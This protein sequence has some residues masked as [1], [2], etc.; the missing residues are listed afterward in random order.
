MV[1]LSSRGESDRSRL[2]NAGNVERMGLERLTRAEVTALLRELHPHLDE[3]L[4]AR[5]A[6]KSDGVPLY[7]LEILPSLEQGREIA[8]PSA[9]REMISV[10]L[11]D[12]TRRERAIIDVSASGR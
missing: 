1:I 7:I 9:I 10:R 5:I 8:V 3:A 4:C 11:R 2:R 6:E 12:L